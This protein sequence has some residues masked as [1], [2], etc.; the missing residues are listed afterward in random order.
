MGNSVLQSGAS[1]GAIIT[2]QVMKLLMT[3]QLGSWRSAFV[4]VG[5]FGLLWV[6]VWLWMM[7]GSGLD[8]AQKE[9]ANSPKRSLD[10]SNLLTNICHHFLSLVILF[11]CSHAVALMMYALFQRMASRGASLL[12]GKDSLSSNTS[13]YSLC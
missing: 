5:A 9:A 2:P 1:I 12:P 13:A 8:E 6:V 4:V 11:A 10:F 7:R 3:E